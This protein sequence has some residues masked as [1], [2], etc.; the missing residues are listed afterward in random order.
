MTTC[1][2]PGSLSTSAFA[3]AA[4]ATARLAT[5]PLSDG[6][7]FLDRVRVDDP[8]VFLREAAPE[9][10]NFAAVFDELLNAPETNDPKRIIHLDGW[11]ALNAHLPPKEKRGLILV[12]R[13]TVAG[14]H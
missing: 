2:T 13:M 1:D 4:S 3:R 12:D 6:D 14:G 8:E 7:V 10:W 5:G 9:D 11:L